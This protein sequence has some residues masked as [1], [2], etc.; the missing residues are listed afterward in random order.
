MISRTSPQRSTEGLANWPGTLIHTIKGLLEKA[1]QLITRFVASRILTGIA[2]EAEASHAPY[3]IERR[4]L[5]VAVDSLPTVN[6]VIFLLHDVYGYRHENIAER[7]GISIS[8]SKSQLH[9]SR[10]KLRTVLINN[11]AIPATPSCREML[12]V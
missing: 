12:I 5:K 8:D 9:F 7:L 2:K 3:G 1:H 6:R 10:M 4:E 11:N